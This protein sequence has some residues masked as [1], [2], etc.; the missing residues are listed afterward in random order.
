MSVAVEL[1]RF[2]LGELAMGELD[3]ID[4]DEDL[5]GSGLLDSFGLQ[6]L[7]EFL[8]TR[9]GIRVSP[10]ELTP[11]HFQTLRS[12]EAFVESQAGSRSC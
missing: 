9:Y 8:Q 5:L 4:P 7:L 11:A 12:M 1:E 10:D 3:R 2:I 6:Q